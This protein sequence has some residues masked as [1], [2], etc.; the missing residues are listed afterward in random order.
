MLFRSKENGDAL[1][2]SEVFLAV[3][4]S[5]HQDDPQ[6]IAMPSWMNLIDDMGS[7]EQNAI[8]ASK[9]YN[10][11]YSPDYNGIALQ[12]LE[13]SDGKL[14]LYDFEWLYAALYDHNRNSESILIKGFWV[15]VFVWKNHAACVFAMCEQIARYLRR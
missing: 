6:N 14:F 2:T 10:L 8:G 3:G 9:V 4:G 15:D 12:F 1:F 7:G 5:E 13:D 11:S